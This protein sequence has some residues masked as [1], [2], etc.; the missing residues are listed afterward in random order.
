MFKRKP[1]DE[2]TETIRQSI[3]T[4]KSRERCIRDYSGSIFELTADMLVKDRLFDKKQAKELSGIAEKILQ[5]YSKLLSV[6]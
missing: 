5:K 6:S 1:F 3:I 2:A 4:A